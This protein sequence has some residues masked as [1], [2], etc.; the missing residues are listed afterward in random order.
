MGKHFLI[1]L[2]WVAFVALSRAQSPSPTPV[3]SP[4][5]TPQ[6]AA[7]P[8]VAAPTP[9]PVLETQ[10]V[11]SI[12][13]QK[14]AVLVNDKVYKSYKIST[15]RY[16]E[17]DGLGSWCTPIGRLAV[18]TK[19]GS[20]VP[21]GGVFQRRRYTGEVLSVNAPGRDPIVSRIIW[22]RGLDY[23][24][25]NAFHRCIY[26]HGTPEED[27]LGKK[28]SYGCIRMRSS[29]V[30]EIFNWINIGTEVAIVDK[31]IGRAV[32]DLAEDRRLMATNTAKPEGKSD[33]VR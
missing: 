12:P 8:V 4:A 20:T 27:N 24:T 5:P 7:P 14:L 13:E 33:L 17:G 9:A 16:G 2:V 28:A 26:I 10:L 1:P 22:L 6:V 32:K 29:D 18:A 15:S 30:I 31:A 23:A 25:R 3:L 11:V 19:I 21:F